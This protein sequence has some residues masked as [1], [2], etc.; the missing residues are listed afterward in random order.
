PPDRVVRGPVAM[1][2]N[3]ARSLELLRQLVKDFP[4]VP[5]YRQD[6][7][8]T[9]ARVSYPGLPSAP[10]SGPAARPLLEE[11]A[12]LSAALVTEYPNVPQY[13]ASRAGV[14]EKLG[15]VLRQLKETEKAEEA[16]RKAVGWQAELVKRHPEVVAYGF[17]LALM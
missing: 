16:L 15:L 12:A 10:A 6:L 3:A 4:K 13:A 14:Q 1:G 8:E 7:C 11:A 2:A 9:L 5:D 17:S